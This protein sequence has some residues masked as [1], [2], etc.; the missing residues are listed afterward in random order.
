MWM[1]VDSED[2]AYARAGVAVA[3]SPLGPF[4]YLGSVRPNGHM[5]RDMTVFQDDDGRAYLFYSSEDN[6]TM[7]VAQL[8]DDYLEPTP[9]SKRLFVGRSRE[10]P[11]VF[12]HAG[13][14]FAVTSGCTGWNPNRAEYAVADSILGDWTVKGDPCRGKGCEVTFESQSTFVLPVAGRP[15]R[16]IF[17]ADR[18][19]PD[20]LEDSRYVWLPIQV[21]GD[22]LSIEWLD[23]WR[24]E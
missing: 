18:W 17:M 1:H 23:E 20:D 4:E 3:E 11:A 9:V 8:S 10:A 2:Y 22:T 5:S 12:K 19:R 15:G 21:D 7:H 13:R 24:L 6:A 16:F 14:N